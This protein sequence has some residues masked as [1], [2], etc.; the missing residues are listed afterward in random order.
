MSFRANLPCRFVLVRAV[1]VACACLTAVHAGAQDFNGDG[2]RDTVIGVPYEDYGATPNAGA[3]DII[4]GS[5]GRFQSP[6]APQH[7]M[8]SSAGIPGSP[9]EDDRFGFAVAWGEFS[10]DQYADLAIGIPGRDVFGIEDA[11]AVVIV[12]GSAQGLVASGPALEDPV[13]FLRQGQD[14]VPGVPKHGDNFGFA[15][16]SLHYS[17]VSEFLSAATPPRTVTTTFRQRS[18]AARPW[19]ASRGGFARPRGLAGRRGSDTSGVSAVGVRAGY[20]GTAPSARARRAQVAASGWDR[21]KCRTIR[22]TERT[23]CTPIVISAC[24]SR[25]TCAPRSAVRSARSCSS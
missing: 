19:I 20:A 10:G 25:G 14:G 2:H 3:V 5:S 13:R 22:R 4:Y 12:H 18:T 1:L 9:H 24:R 11:G 17:S 21:G 8:L 6:I 23:T 15:L 7:W 16:A